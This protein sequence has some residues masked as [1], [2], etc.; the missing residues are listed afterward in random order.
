[1]WFLFAFPFRLPFAFY[2]VCLLLL[3]VK[4]LYACVN[5]NIIRMFHYHAVVVYLCKK[6]RFACGE[7]LIFDMYGDD[8]MMADILFTV[9]IVVGIDLLY[10][11]SSQGLFYTPLAFNWLY[12]GIAT[13][14]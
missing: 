7:T 2:A 4:V 9:S 14:G 1:M 12:N 8:D 6:S 13:S 5:V 3:A 11:C 10:P